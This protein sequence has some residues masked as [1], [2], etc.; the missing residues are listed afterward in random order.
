METNQQQALRQPP[1][2]RSSP[3]RPSPEAVPEQVGATADETPGLDEI[4]IVELMSLQS[5]PA[6]DPP[7][8][9]AG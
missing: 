3:D 5:F 1:Q 2:A 7:A 4:D 9:W 6:S 8:F